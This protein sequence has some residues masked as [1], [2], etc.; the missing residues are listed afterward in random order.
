MALDPRVGI[1]S[2]R[3]TGRLSGVFVPIGITVSRDRLCLSRRPGA[4]PAVHLT[5][6]RWLIRYQMD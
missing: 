6:K 2:Q 3:D 1:E 5:L 4:T